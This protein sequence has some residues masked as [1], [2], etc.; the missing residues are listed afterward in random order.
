M[1][2]KKLNIF[3]LLANKH[4]TKLFI[5]GVVLILCPTFVPI[6]CQ[7]SVSGAFEGRVGNS[8]TGLMITGVNIEITNEST[9]RR[10]RSTTN[11]LGIFFQ[12]QLI[13]GWY[14][15]KIEFPGLEPEVLRRRVE[16]GRTIEIV[17]S[18]IMLKPSGTAISGLNE[19]E[20]EIRSK[21]NVIDARHDDSR[22][23]EL[24]DSPIG[25]STNS[26]S[27][28]E[29]ALFTLG[30][31]SPP[32]TIGSIAGPG[33]GPGVGSA[34]QFAANGLRSRANN[35]TVDGSDNNDEDIGVRRQGFFSL[36]PQ[37][38]ESVQEYQI[39]SLLA[40]AQYGRNIGAQ[41]N[42]VSKSGGNIVHG[43]VYASASTGTFNARN[44][45]DSVCDDNSFAI[46]T[47]DGR[48]VL[49]DGAEMIAR[50]DSGRKSPFTYGHI[51]AT[52]GGPVRRD[53]T[54]YF[55]SA[56]YQRETGFQ[57]THFAVPTVEQRGI[58]GTGSTG[59][60][61]DP[62]T[63]IPV[64][65]IPATL[66]GGALFSLFPFPNNPE[67]VFG[68]NTFTNE[69][70]LAS[71]GTITSARIDDVFRWLKRDHDLTGRYNFTDDKR[72]IPTVNDALFSTV[73]AKIR[74]HN[75]SFIAKTELSGISSTD[76]I[77]NQLRVSFGRTTLD[78]R[79]PPQYELLLPSDEF[80]DDP[81]LLNAHLNL[82][83]TTGPSQGVPASGP[84]TFVGRFNPVPSLPGQTTVEQLLGPIGQVN[85][86]GFSQLGLDVFNFPQFRV[87]DTYQLAD[88][89][90]RRA[91]AH[92]FVIGFDSRYTR[93]LSDLPRLSRPYVSFNGSPR[94]SQ[95]GS[96]PCVNGGIGDFCFPTPGTPNAILRAED[97]AALGATSN[98]TMAFNVDRPG[99]KID[100][101]FVQLN[102][103][104]QDTWRFTPD[105]SISYGIRYEYNSP[106]NEKERL[107]EDTFDDPRLELVPGIR[108]FLNGRERLYEPDSNNLAPRLG[109]AF[110]PKLFGL[111]RTSVFRA[112][113]GVYY[114]QI[115]GAVA[116]Q[117]R[118]VFPSFLTVN[119][120]AVNFAGEQ[121]LSF[122]NPGDFRF[123]QIPLRQPGTLNI[124]NPAIP[125]ADFM[126]QLKIFFP[127]A[128]TA[129]LP[130]SKLKM[131]IAIHYV[132]EFEQQITERYSL[133]I[134]YVGTRS[135]SLLRFE[136]PNLGP[137]LTTAPST[138]G[139][140]KEQ[141]GGA[142]TPFPYTN[143]FLFNPNRAVRDI[144]AITLFTS[145]AGSNYNALQL[146]LNGRP[147]EGFELSANYAFS[148][149]VDDVSDV[150]D[151][152]GASALPQNSITFEGERALANFDRTHRVTFQFNYR[153]PTRTKVM[154][155]LFEDLVISGT[156]LIQSGQPF[157]VNSLVD[158]NL[159]GNLTD[160]LDTVTGISSTNNRSR[161]FEL[162]V[163]PSTLLAAFGTDGDVHR[164][165]FRG[166][167]Y[168][169]FDMALSKPVTIGTTKVI[170]RTEIFNIFNRSNFG[171]PIRF[172]EAAGFGRSTNTVS[173]NKRIQFGV[174]LEI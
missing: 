38:I 36:V 58:F 105:V 34:G 68:Q 40:P 170:L 24:E 131:P 37:S 16:L 43:N 158:V 65:A 127:N 88:E 4:K 94:L 116:S 64:K 73:E 91:G 35:F 107:I 48:S 161:P 46:K 77:F 45:F 23:K 164:N 117:S 10:Y 92:S 53:K 156:G 109:I 166:T 147:I 95:R 76:P 33:V 129:T 14:L 167:N 84:V 75:F 82:N 163:D 29:L 165:S 118:N 71:N 85:L 120:G 141:V 18:P 122:I 25:G 7:D 138:L 96:G 86:A 99:A 154:S 174:K 79:K 100:L 22:T 72:S 50:F 111:R 150:F 70:P 152:S 125:F 8:S 90:T 87:N 9:G 159:D 5:T 149:A 12:G 39:I 78:F 173:P 106:V 123:D 132:A 52:V 66:E 121:T 126:N 27:F 98:F 59:L 112:G 67:G 101:R 20:I 114:D 44:F 31:T 153:F 145:S 47:A 42:A 54:F 108:R 104:F 124:I 93:L 2:S 148:R 30:V 17:P 139:I 130:Q 133:L 69:L 74:T 135:R 1:R 136:S 102:G 155:W 97:Q 51:G 6:F 55:L 144:G 172:L 169:Q 21:I 113:V 49:R 157:T 13:P 168:V 81:Y 115:L 140:V 128:I 28:D 3:G 103:F 11:S 171:I 151:L 119:F 160:R 26:R 143:G 89:L 80:P 15:L 142:L 57:E 62:F 19:A 60:F 110:A 83:V 137:N 134:S 63:Q 41:V 56:E 146:E 162:S 32:L 61:L